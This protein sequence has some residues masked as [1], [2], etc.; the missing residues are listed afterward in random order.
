M[1]QLRTV[2]LGFARAVAVNNEDRPGPRLEQNLVGNSSTSPIAILPNPW[3]KDLMLDEALSFKNGS[4][5]VFV[6]AV[7]V[8]EFVVAI[9]S[10]LWSRS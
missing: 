3:L 10:S 1:D 5:G 7:M 2:P 4:F 8:F 9:G 6:S